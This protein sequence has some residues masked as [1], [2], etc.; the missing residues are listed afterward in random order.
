MTEQAFN[1]PSAGPGT[2]KVWRVAVRPL[3][4]LVVYAVAVALALVIAVRFFMSEGGPATILY[5]ALVS[6]S[7]GALALLITRRLL[8][9][10]LVVALQVLILSIASALKLKYVNMVLHAYDIAFYLTSPATLSFL[11][12][13]YRG[14]VLLASGALLL[15]G[16]V[17]ALAW[18]LDPTRFVRRRTALAAFTLMMGTWGAAVLTGERRHSQF[19]YEGQYISSFY[20]SWSETIE[21]LWRGQLIEAAPKGSAPL[22]RVDAQCEPQTKPPHII[23]IHQESVVPPGI[24]PKLDYNRALDSFFRSDDGRSYTLRVETYGGN[25]TLTEFSVLTGL[26]TYA[27]GGMRQFVQHMMAGKIKDTLPQTLAR[28]GY[29]NVLFYP[30]LKSFVYADKFFKGVGLD[31]I[32]DLKAQK[33]TRVDERDGFYYANAM[34]EMAQHF[35]TSKA[36]LF[37]FIETMATHWPYDIPFEPKLDVPGGAPGTH[38]EMHEYLRRLWLAHGDYE[39]LRRELA[40]RFPDEKFLIVRYGDHHPM[41]TRM[42]LGFKEGTEAE[43]VLLDRDSLGFKTFYAING[44]NTTPQ[45]ATLPQTLDAP[46]LG[47]VLLQAAGLPLSDAYKARAELMSACD[48]RWFDCQRKGAVLAFQRQLLDSG[49]IT[50]R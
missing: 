15:T 5:A 29:R 42:L 34:A 12:D 2:G 37:T 40:R 30:M 3:S 23:L 41:A 50:A 24:L 7:I 16:L 27:F 1:L 35:A 31:E 6:L 8:V 19:E 10:A 26:S 17:L 9:A 44:V 33:A 43:D 20:L 47:T 18:R 38:P 36:P 4:P 49:L 14:L 21:T 39:E 46:Y 48:G 32:F 13:S 45:S 22:L 11:W 25:S 28:C